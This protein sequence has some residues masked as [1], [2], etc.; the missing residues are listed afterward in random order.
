[1]SQP[2]PRAFRHA[3]RG[4]WAAL[5]GQR[6][7]R[8]HLAVTLIVAIAGWILSLSPLEWAVI[9][10][11]VGLVWAAELTNTAIEAIVDLVNPA[12]HPLAGAAKDAAAAAVLATA[13]A[14]ALVGLIILLSQIIDR[15]M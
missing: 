7:L 10:L 1:M 14:A 9:I 12:Y 6:N 4:L 3:F 5:C 2:L 8:I 13:V 15:V 11:A